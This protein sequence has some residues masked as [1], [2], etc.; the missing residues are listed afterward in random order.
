M[1]TPTPARLLLVFGGRSSEHEISVRSARELLQA[2]DTDRFAVELLGI[3]R[4]GVMRRG[5]S[6]DPRRQAGYLGSPWVE[7]T[8]P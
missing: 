4:T 1:S 7:S 3:S 5:V 6:G 2:I 8:G